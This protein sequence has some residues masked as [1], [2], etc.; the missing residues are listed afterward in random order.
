ML[1]RE[2][3]L[4]SEFNDFLVSRLALENRDYY[5]ELDTEDFIKLKSIFRNV[6]NI[7]TLKL[8]FKFVEILSS[9]FEL[10]AEDGR[11]IVD[12]VQMVSPNAN[13]FDVEIEK[14]IKLVAEVKGNVPVNGG[15]VFG[16]AQQREIKKDLCSLKN[17]KTKSS[18]KPDNFYKFMVFPD[19]N[20][21]RK[22]VEKLLT[23]LKSSNDYKD[24]SFEI[25]SQNTKALETDRIYI[26]FV[27]ID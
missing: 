19:I 22:A 11:E 3:K 20:A 10:S 8:T 15:V 21:T 1:S 5:G 26:V 7:I 24:Y 25:V 18:I 6:N 17:G 2:E 23:L 16:A 4:K 9:L 13:G 12:K 14:P 27:G